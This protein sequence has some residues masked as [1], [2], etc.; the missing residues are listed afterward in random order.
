MNINLLSVGL[1]S[2]TVSLRFNV[3]NG[4][5]IFVMLLYKTS[6]QSAIGVNYSLIDINVRFLLTSS[7]FT[8]TINNSRE[9][10]V[11]LF[12]QFNLKLPET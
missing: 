1:S 8:V 7:R 12:I 11:T 5:V 9:K 6:S 3:L 4:P 2:T 10:H